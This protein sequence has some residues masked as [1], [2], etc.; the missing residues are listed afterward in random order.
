MRMAGNVGCDMEDGLARGWR[1]KKAA[2]DHYACVPLRS[3]P[4]PLPEQAILVVNAHSRKGREA[5]DEAR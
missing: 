3:L 1:G 2:A 4:R 5:F